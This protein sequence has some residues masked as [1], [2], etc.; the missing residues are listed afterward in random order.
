MHR[1]GSRMSHRSTVSDEIGCRKSVKFVAFWLWFVAIGLLASSQ[2]Q[3]VALETAEAA[4]EDALLPPPAIVELKDGSTIVGE[5]VSMTNGELTMKTTFAGEVKI[6]WEEVRKIASPTKL[7]IVLNDGNEPSATLEES[8]PDRMSI[9]TDGGLQSYELSA[10][11]AINPPPIKPVNYR[12]NLNL[13]GSVS[14]GNTQRKSV[15]SNAEFVARSKRQRFTLRA[16]VNYAEETG[17]VYQRNAMGSVKYDFFTTERVF[18]Y[19]SSLFEGDKFQN[20]RLRTALSTGFGYQFLNRGELENEYLSRLEGY[21]EIGV[22]YFA[23]DFRTGLDNDFVA[24]RWAFNIDWE[25]LPEQMSF[26][27][28][29]EGFPGFEDFEDLY[30]VTEQGLR[31]FFTESFIAS[32]QINWRWDNT[33]APGFERSDTIYLVTLGYNFDI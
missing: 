2:P 32:F 3:L 15:N 10:V 11:N 29:H 17:T 9:R 23:E 31:V 28:R 18:I 25:F 33:P 24:G 12:G 19:V 6:K 16:A 30:L 8:D 26:F 5:I 13:G 4:A 22:A 14:D 1:Q 20:L 21:A 7:K 27:H